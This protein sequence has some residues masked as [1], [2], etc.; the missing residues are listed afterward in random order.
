MFDGVVEQASEA[1]LANAA[2]QGD[3]SGMYNCPHTGVALAVLLK[4]KEQGIIKKNDRTVVI[5]TAHGLKFSEFKVKYHTRQLEGVDC[6]YAN[7]P[8][9]LPADVD[10]VKETIFS[11]L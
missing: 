9:E 2:E 5:S 6:K 10:K 3:R 8:F 7:T 1:E 11:N 4:M